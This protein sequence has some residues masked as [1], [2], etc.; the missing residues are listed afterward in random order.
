MGKVKGSCDV[1]ETQFLCGLTIELR[2]R[3][4]GHVQ[5]SWSHGSDRAGL[6]L[7]FSSHVRDA[8]DS[9]FS[10]DGDLGLSMISEGRE[11]QR[12]FTE[13]TVVTPRIS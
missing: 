1:Q 2:V 3:I 13:V 8:D 10:I 12:V 7:I 9:T 11:I 5:K 4:D 6:N